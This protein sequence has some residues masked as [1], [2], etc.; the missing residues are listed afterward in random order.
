ML[1]WLANVALVFFTG[2]RE[3]PKPLS[4]FQQQWCCRDLLL[5]HAL[6]VAYVPAYNDGVCNA[7]NT[8]IS[9]TAFDVVYNND[10][11]L[12]IFD[13]IDFACNFTPSLIP[14]DNDDWDVYNYYND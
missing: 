13:A 10:P 1:R 3:T 12:N 5:Q 11:A 7:V 6:N 8:T 2:M 14:Q 9:A 4:A